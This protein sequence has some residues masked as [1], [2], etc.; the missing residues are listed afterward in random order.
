M[1][2]DYVKQSHIRLRLMREALTLTRREFS[3]LLNVKYRTYNGWEKKDRIISI[4]AQQHMVVLGL[5]PSY[6]LG[7]KNITI[8]DVPF[9]N[10]KKIV[11]RKLMERVNNGIY[12]N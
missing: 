9:E 10:V 1:I 3:M 8:N 2:E 12:N 7:D 5:N 4:T 6:I 11:F